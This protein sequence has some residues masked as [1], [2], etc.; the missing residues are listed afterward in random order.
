[1]GLTGPGGG[2]HLGRRSRYCGPY[3]RPVFDAS[4]PSS[5]RGASFTAPIS[6]LYRGS[7][8]DTTCRAPDPPA[9][10]PPA[11]PRP[12]TSSPGCCRCPSRPAGGTRSARTRGTAPSAAPRVP[13]RSRAAP[14][15]NCTTHAF[16]APYVPRGRKAATD[17][18]LTTPPRPRSRIA[19]GRRR[20]QSQHRL[21]VHLQHRQ[22]V[23]HR[24]VE[25]TALVAEP[26]VVDQ[27]IDRVSAVARARVLDRGDPVFGGRGRRSAPRP[28]CRAGRATR[29]PVP[30]TARCRAP[31]APGCARPPPAAARTRRRCPPSSP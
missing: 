8:I 3:L 28:R 24:D 29:W 22:L 13:A 15:V 18:T 10:P 9:P 7:G 14:C 27:Q 2:F 31:P 20:C 23:G 1:M 11:C 30:A 5:P 19:G 26:G 16:E 21:A 17:A 6:A 4:P 12:A 25:E